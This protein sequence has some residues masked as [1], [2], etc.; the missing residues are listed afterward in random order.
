MYII[1]Y[2]YVYDGEVVLIYQFVLS[3]K[4]STNLLLYKTFRLTKVF[5]KE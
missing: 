4:K 3:K 2:Q 5:F 1:I